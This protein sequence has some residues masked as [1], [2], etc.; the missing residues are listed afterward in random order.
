MHK[1]P[2][3]AAE[4]RQQRADLRQAQHQ[5]HRGQD[6]GSRNACYPQT[7]PAQRGLRH[8][9]HDNPERDRA[10]RQSR[11]LD[12]CRATLGCQPGCETRNEAARCFTLAIENARD[13]DR[14]EHVNHE[15]AHSR[16]MTEHPARDNRQIRFQLRQNAA[17][18]GVRQGLP[19]M[20]DALPGQRNLTD[21][22]GRR[23]QCIAGQKLDGAHDVARVQGQCRNGLVERQCN[24]EQQDD[25]HHRGGNPSAIADAALHRQHHGPG[26]NH[27]SGRPNEPRNKRPQDIEAAD[28]Q[29]GQD[30]NN[31]QNAGNIDWLTRGHFVLLTR[32]SWLYLNARAEHPKPNSAARAAQRARCLT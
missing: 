18:P 20:R 5:H 11:Q 3:D 16:C 19:F 14:D 25:Q 12:R 4:Q 28:G 10:N 9:C 31:E 23:R 7:D 8:R 15:H 29:R 26:G 6:P 22:A 30:D 24:H 13:D 2:R 17:R 32:I 1:K 21:P 27:N